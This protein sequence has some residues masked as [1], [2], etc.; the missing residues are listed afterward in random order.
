MITSEFR[1]QVNKLCTEFWTGGIANP[2]MVIEQISFLMFACLL[3]IREIREGKK[4]RRTKKS[5]KR[6]FQENKQYLRWSHFNK[7]TPKTECCI[8]FGI[9]QKRI[10]QP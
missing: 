3:D 10:C 1:N 7:M 4:A 9:R 8:L 2:L 5:F 6:I